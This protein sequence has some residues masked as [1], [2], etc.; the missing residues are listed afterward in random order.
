[1]PGAPQPSFVDE[2]IQAPAGVALLARLEATKRDDVSRFEC[3]TDCNHDSVRLAALSIQEMPYG[4]LLEL[5]VSAAQ[6]FAGPWSGQALTSLPYLYEHAKHRRQIAEALSARFYLPLHRDPDLGA[7]QWWYEE[8]INSQQRAG[9]TPCFTNYT[10]CYGNGEFTWGG[11]WTI[12]DPPP[13]IHDA[14]ILTWDF[15]GWPT[16]RW[17]LPVRSDARVW[18]INR[19][20]DWTR[21]VETYPKA[22]AHPHAGWELPGPNQHPSDTKLLRSLATQH[23]VRSEIAL[24]VLP[25]WERVAADFDGVHLS[26]AG[27]LTTEGFI[28]DL[29][30]GGVTMMRFWGSEHTLWLHDVFETPVPLEA[31][32][33]TGSVG[34]GVGVDASTDDGRRARDSRALDTLLGR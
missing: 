15:F 30:N 9:I 13:Q 25:D 24:H 20:A 2:L 22:A 21:L 18:V 23:A 5:A 33:L 6:Q 14:L 28:S 17:L 26:W 29:S 34:G 19:P 12:T 16:S 31:P 4:E 32:M 3:P 11:L 27:F 1:M 7:Q 10:L 8:P